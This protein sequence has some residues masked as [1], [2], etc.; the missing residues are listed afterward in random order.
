MTPRTL[1]QE[2]VNPEVVRTLVVEGIVDVPACEYP[3]THAEKSPPYWHEDGRPACSICHP[4]TRREETHGDM[5][6]M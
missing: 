1:E 3:R 6:A 4:Q 5:R 2:L